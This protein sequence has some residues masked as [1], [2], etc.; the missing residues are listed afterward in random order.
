MAHFPVLNCVAGGVQCRHVPQRG[1]V[2]AIILPHVIDFAEILVIIT[3]FGAVTTEPVFAGWQWF[4]RSQIAA[5][6]AAVL[7]C[8]FHHFTFLFRKSPAIIY[9][10][11]VFWPVCF[12]PQ[13]LMCLRVQPAIFPQVADNLSYHRARCIA[14]AIW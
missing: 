14:V 5:T 3:F 11:R 12:L 6:F 2:I 10:R 4:A 7:D 8:R 9:T 1:S 13:R